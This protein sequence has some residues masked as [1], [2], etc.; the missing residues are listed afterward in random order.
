MKPNSLFPFIFAVCLFAV[1][2]LPIFSEDSK[3]TPPPPPPPQEQMSFLDNG[4]IRLGIDL[5]VGGSITYLSEA[6]GPNLVNS[7]DFGR[8][9][10]M[11]FYSGP[12]PYE[13]N[14]KKPTPTW[15]GLGW[16]PIQSGDCAGVRSKVLEH[17]NDGKRL[18]VKCVPMQWPLN[19]VP[20]A[21]VFES[22]LELDGATVQ[23]RC[24]IT[25]ARSEKDFFPAR[26]QEQPAVYTNGPW[27]KLMSY[28]GDK[29]FTGGPLTRIERAPD[30]KREFPWENWK[31]T[32][33]WAALV[34]DDDRG[35]GVWAPDTFDFVGGF[36]GKPGQGGPKDNPTGYIAPIRNEIL[37]HNIQ[38]EYRYTLIV[39]SLQE[40]RDYVYRVARRDALPAWRFE[41]DRQ[42][43]TYENLTDGGWPIAGEL[44][45]TFA[46]PV[47]SLISPSFWTPAEQARFLKIEAASTGQIKKGRL[48]FKTAESAGF[49]ETRA[50][51]FALTSN[52]EFQTCRIDLSACPA[53]RGIVTGIRLDPALEAGAGD[54]LRVRKIGF[55][56]E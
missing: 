18:Y 1:V 50:V 7:F 13:P 10:Q 35:L 23:A 6:K 41:A 49:D 25:N 48:Y 29:P 44:R 24:R 43:W 42:H 22:W 8:Q 46:K 31:A 40:I 16:N 17:T 47:G 3:G 39:G 52:G 9:I 15:A 4:T 32:E 54:T 12:V 38:Y 34:G 26:S 27:Y 56:K 33:N 21:C 36:Y 51:D 2:T 5:N 19:N 30:D 45:F 11:S 37:D 55:E 53:W 28:K 14:G 20:G